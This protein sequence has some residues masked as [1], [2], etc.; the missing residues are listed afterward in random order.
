VPYVENPAAPLALVPRIVMAAH[1]QLLYLRDQLAPFWLST[2]HSYAE[3][4]SGST[5]EGPLA[6]AMAVVS[7]IA[8]WTAWT[9]R[10]NRPELALSVLGYALLLA[11]VGNFI[12]TIGTIMG[13]RLLYIPSLFLCL[14]IASFLSRIPSRAVS[15]SIVVAITAILGIASV[16]QSRVWKD[17]LTLFR[18]Q[19]ATAPRSA[20]SHGNLGEALRAA[21]RARE[22][23][24]ELLKSIEI[25]EARPEP[26]AGL[27]RAYEDLG[28][29]PE[30]ILE[31]W[32][33]SLRYGTLAPREVRVPILIL[34]DLG[35]WD[36]LTSRR[37]ALATADPHDPI[38]E[39]IDHVL[40]AADALLR[41]TRADDDLAAAQAAFG[42][43]QWIES[44][45]LFLR[46]LHKNEVPRAILPDA[47][48]RIASCY[49][50][51][52]ASSKAGWYRRIAESV[53]A[54]P[55]SARN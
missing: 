17:D 45:S 18:E 55:E 26:H 1:V 22:A 10:R 35:R 38:L 7:A 30:L 47:V 44:K 43:G 27:G 40:R 51:L 37:G 28:E 6:A 21:G 11:P 50:K 14:W 46:A 9:T 39:P 31:A 19:V 52:G 16:R 54:E 4:R 24:G 42:R 2:D 41:T 23:V 33:D 3:I 15:T 13:D 20:K 34:I 5:M 49:E 25:Y 8:A 53:R 29:D 12:V 48:D 36:T 32:T